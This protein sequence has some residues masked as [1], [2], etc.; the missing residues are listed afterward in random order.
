MLISLLWMLNVQAN[1]FVTNISNEEIDLQLGGTWSI[2][3]HDGYRWWL[4]M[5]QASDLWVAPLYDNNWYVEMPLTQ[6]LSNQGVSLI[7]LFDAVLMEHTF[8]LALAMLKTHITSFA[9]TKTSNVG[10]QSI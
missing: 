7:T 2:P 1:T 10:K 6:N 9:M 5:G 4:G 8:T 3:F